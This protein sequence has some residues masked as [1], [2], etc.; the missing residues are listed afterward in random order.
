MTKRIIAIAV[1]YLV[2][3]AG[4][5]FLGGT[6]S[7]RTDRQDAELKS[8]VGQLWGIPLEQKA[9]WGVIAAETTAQTSRPNDSGNGVVYVRPGATSETYEAPIAE[10]NI[11]VS[12]ELD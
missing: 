8:S 5:I 10:N 9:P 6:I 11:N 2:A 4:W 3:V 12:F 7:Y 1:V